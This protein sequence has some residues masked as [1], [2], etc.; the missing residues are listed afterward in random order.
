MG[1]ELRPTGVFVP[2]VTPFDADDMVDLD[3]LEALAAG[4]LQEGAAGLVALGTTGEP[5]SLDEAERE[6]VVATIASVCADRGGTL[7][8]GAGTNDTRTTI[9][10]HE[11][12]S[13]VPG[14]AVSLT[15]APYYVR[16]SEAA[17]VRHFDVDTLRLLAESGG[18][19]GRAARRG[20][21][22]DSARAD[23]ACGCVA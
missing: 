16:P 18:D 15:V 5:T 23:A 9:G 19:Q 3:S 10:L 17:I 6:A 13:D 11:A 8:V 12:L 22:P 4:V 14:A 21:D 2:L 1:S 7:I 20:P